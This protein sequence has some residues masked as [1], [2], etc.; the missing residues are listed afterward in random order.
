VIRPSVSL[1][2]L[3]RTH[4]CGRT[5]SPKI[6]TPVSRGPIRLRTSVFKYSGVQ[7][8]R[9]VK[10][11]RLATTHLVFP[12]KS[13]SAGSLS[14]HVLI[15]ERLKLRAIAS[16]KYLWN[17]I[18]QSGPCSSINGQP[19]RALTHANQWVARSP[20]SISPSAWWILSLLLWSPDKRQR[21][22]S[23]EFS[24]SIVYPFDKNRFRPI[25]LRK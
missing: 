16:I 6:A 11:G 23:R 19:S 1:S 7:T 22:F 4:P 5:A 15:K 9:P 8:R 2:A 10:A 3:R 14:F 21:S 20:T 13:I 17:T 18:L 24:S 12:A 25:R